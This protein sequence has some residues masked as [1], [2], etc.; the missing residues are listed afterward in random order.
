ML[1]YIVYRAGMIPLTLTLTWVFRGLIFYPPVGSPCWFF[2]NNS[3][4]VRAVTLGLGSIQSF[5]LETLV[6]NLVFLTRPSPH[7]LY[8]NQTV[9]FP[10]YIFL[11]NSF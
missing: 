2:L 6:P 7:I 11:V 10:I 5:L 4:A 1:F 8:K 3:E 9:L